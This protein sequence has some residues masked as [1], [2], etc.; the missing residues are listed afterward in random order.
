MLTKKATKRQIAEW[1]KLF[2]ENKDSLSPNRKTGQEVDEYFRA[3]Y[4]S[5]PL[6]DLAVKAAAE[7][8]ILQDE[9]YAAKLPA[10]V[11]PDVNCYQAGAA[12]VAIDLVSGH[13]HVECAD[14]KQ[15]ERI[16]D[17][18]FAFRGLDESDLQNYFLVAQYLLCKKQ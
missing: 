4:P 10:G 17:D 13:I 9:Y 7:E 16:Y 1:K 3:R 14:K 11:L 18:L 8:T 5:T 15:M 12:I 6:S 2:A